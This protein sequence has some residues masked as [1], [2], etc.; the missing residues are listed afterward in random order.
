MS[1]VLTL[2][3]DAASGTILKQVELFDPDSL[4]VLVRSP[5]YQRMN[6]SFEYYSDAFTCNS[7]AIAMLIYGEDDRRQPFRRQELTYCSGNINSMTSISTM[8]PPTTVSGMTTPSTQPAP[9][10]SPGTT[11]AP[12]PSTSAATATVPVVPTTSPAM[13]LAPTPLSFDIVILIDVSKSA[14]T[15][16]DDMSLFV[17]SLMAS[18]AVSQEY[19]RV[20]VVPVF[21][22]AM[23][24][25]MVIANLNAIGSIDVL[26]GYLEQTKEFGDFD[27]V[28]EALAQG[29]TTTMNT[30]FKNSGYRSGIT[31]H[32]VL[33]ITAT[34]GFTDQP[35]AVAQQVLQTGGYGIVTIGYG[36]GVTDLVSLQGLA[37]GYQCSF[38]G[39]DLPILLSRTASV[40]SLIAAAD[41]NGGKYCGN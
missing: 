1:N 13:T 41:A 31:N 20:A 6:C 2:H 28:G 34:T 14:S 5:L 10:T 38:Y 9:S 7:E 11:P 15:L 18:F 17:Y 27:D 16:Y 32:L 29:L 19:A 12:A 23:Y 3:A 25:P 21:G 30:D 33:Y 4:T 35:Q 37:G 26:Q 40:Q 24:G 36:T 22:D 39:A 8:S